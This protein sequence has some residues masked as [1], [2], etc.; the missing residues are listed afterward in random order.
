MNQPLLP[1]VMRLPTLAD[2]APTV[3]I[4][5]LW[6]QGQAPDVKKFLGGASD[7]SPAQVV[8]VLAIGG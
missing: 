5:R 6:K 1:T 8:A 2:D 7:L 4:R 3:Q